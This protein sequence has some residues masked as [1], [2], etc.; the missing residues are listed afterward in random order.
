MVGERYMT[1][2]LPVQVE[3]GE[4]TLAQLQR[5]KRR[6][7]LC[8]RGSAMGQVAN[9]NGCQEVQLKEFTLR[10]VRGYVDVVQVTIK[11]GCPSGK[12]MHLKW[13]DQSDCIEVIPLDRGTM[14]ASFS[15][16]ELTLLF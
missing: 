5:L 4:G 11:G 15:Q 6:F 8:R 16:P 7:D 12:H 1:V 3:D 13:T 14:L 2:Q 10:P 9:G